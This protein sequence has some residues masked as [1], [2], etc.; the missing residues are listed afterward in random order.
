MNIGAQNAGRAGAGG[1]LTNMQSAAAYNALNE[2]QYERSRAKMT[3]VSRAS[4]AAAIAED[5][6]GAK[7]RVAGLDRRADDMAEYYRSQRG[8]FDTLMFGDYMNPFF[9]APRFVVPEAP[10]VIKVED[11]TKS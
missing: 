6:I 5:Q 10:S 11:P 3:G 9:K 7:N 8:R 1:G 2:N 4:M